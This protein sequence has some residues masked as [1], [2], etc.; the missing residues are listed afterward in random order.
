MPVPKESVPQ[1]IRDLQQHLRDYVRRSQDHQLRL[2][3]FQEERRRRQQE[4]ELLLD[5]GKALTAATQTAHATSV[6][7]GG[8]Y[9]H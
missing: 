9:Q 7:V 5:A 1:E 2:Q 8:R 4:R 3:A 6:A